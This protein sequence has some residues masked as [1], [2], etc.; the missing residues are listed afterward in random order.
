MSMLSAGLSC[1]SPVPAPRQNKKAAI[2]ITLRTRRPMGR[3]LP[4]CAVRFFVFTVPRLG[5]A[6]HGVRDVVSLVGPWSYTWSAQPVI[7]YGPTWPD[8]HASEVGELCVVV[9]GRH[10]DPA[11]G[12][13]DRYFD[14]GDALGAPAISARADLGHHD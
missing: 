8:A 13:I 3:P 4:S 1:A 11:R 12:G 9:V 7:G 6:E 2:I 14:R 5:G 10:P